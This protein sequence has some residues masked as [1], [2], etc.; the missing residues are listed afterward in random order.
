MQISETLKSLY[1][2][3]QNNIEIELK[4]KTQKYI[5]KMYSVFI[6]LYL[7]NYFI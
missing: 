6:F 7:D 2:T 4:K 5:F 1:I 3:I